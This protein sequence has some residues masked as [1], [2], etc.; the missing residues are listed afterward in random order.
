MKINLNSIRIREINS[1]DLKNDDSGLWFRK[2]KHMEDLGV[3][4]E[5]HNDW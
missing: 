2:T 3:T 5:K 4:E 1:K